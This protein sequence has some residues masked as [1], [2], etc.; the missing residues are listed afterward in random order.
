MWVNVVFYQN[1]A[2]SGRANSNGSRLASD[3]SNSVRLSMDEVIKGIGGVKLK[4]IAR[5]QLILSLLLPYCDSGSVTTQ[6]PA[7]CFSEIKKTVL[8]LF[9]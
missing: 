9:E 3:N 7:T 5:Y 1:K 4:K 8:W 2:Q 6:R